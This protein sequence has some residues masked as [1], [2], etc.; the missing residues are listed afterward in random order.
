MAFKMFEENCF[1]DRQKYQ[2]FGSSIVAVFKKMGTSRL[3]LELTL[4]IVTLITGHKLPPHLSHHKDPAL[5]GLTP[6]YF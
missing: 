5:T 2:H 3:H 6:S 1:P 4:S